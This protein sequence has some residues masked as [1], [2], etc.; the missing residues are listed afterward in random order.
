MTLQKG[1]YPSCPSVHPGHQSITH[2]SEERKS[3]TQCIIKTIPWNYTALKLD[4]VLAV[5]IFF[6][7]AT[8]ANG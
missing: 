2:T 6:L 1:I 7:I 5:D 8:V 3:N 4:S